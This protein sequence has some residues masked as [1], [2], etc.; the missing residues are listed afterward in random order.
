MNHPKKHKN[1][2]KLDTKP[3]EDGLK[4]NKYNSKKQKDDIEDILSHPQQLTQQMQKNQLSIRESLPK[5]Q[6]NDLQQ[7][8]NYIKKQYPQHSVILDIGSGI[9]F[10]RKGFLKLFNKIIE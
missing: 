6:K 8:I 10:K 4:M 1:I 9:N 7:Q 3:L 5:N 2:I